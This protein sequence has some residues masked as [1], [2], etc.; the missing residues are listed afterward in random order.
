MLATIT[1][2]CGPAAR[3][4]AALAATGLK[5]LSPVAAVVHSFF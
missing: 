3:S 1:D 4:I 2:A 5:A